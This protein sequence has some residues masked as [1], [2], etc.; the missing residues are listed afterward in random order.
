MDSLGAGCLCF[1]R[2]IRW[3][4]GSAGPQSTWYARWDV[5]VDCLE[6]KSRL[7][8]D[9]IIIPELLFQFS[10]G[11]IIRSPGVWLKVI[12]IATQNVPNRRKIKSVQAPACCLHINGFNNLARKQGQVLTHCLKE[13]LTDHVVPG[14]VVC[15]HVGEGGGVRLLTDRHKLHQQPVLR[16]G[17]NLCTFKG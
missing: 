15:G 7:V 16:R 11:A 1:L 2:V 13:S 5:T 17:G 8:F 12:C 9:K 14:E 6:I 10:L 3:P 4:D